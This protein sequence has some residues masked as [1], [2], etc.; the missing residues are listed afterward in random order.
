MLTKRLGECNRRVPRLAEVSFKAG[1]FTV[2]WAINDNL[3]TSWIGFGARQDIVDVLKAVDELR[4]EYDGVHVMGTFAM[5]DVYGNT[6]ESI[7]I[8]L[9][10]SEATIDQINWSGIDPDD[11][12]TIADTVLFIHP[13][14]RPR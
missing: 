11:I 14:V 12:Y 3:I 2:Q 1:V 4:M 9:E 6:R 10:Y 13:E 5:T 8:D 7:I